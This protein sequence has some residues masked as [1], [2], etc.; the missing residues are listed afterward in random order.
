MCRWQFAAKVLSRQ[1]HAPVDDE[2]HAGGGVES[3]KLEY[4]LEDMSAAA[5]RSDAQ[6]D[7]T[8]FTALQEKLGLK[9]ESR[10]A[11]TE[12]LVIHHAEKPNVD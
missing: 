6:D 8:V 7:V 9:L 5:P 12:I 1:L 11:P 4:T 2:T 10:N 3:F